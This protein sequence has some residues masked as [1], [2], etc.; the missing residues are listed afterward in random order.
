MTL[1]GLAALKT[2]IL[3]WAG[4]LLPVGLQ[5]FVLM[6]YIA[7]SCSVLKFSSGASLVD[8]RELVIYAF[9]FIG[10]ALSLNTLRRK[11]VDW[12]EGSGQRV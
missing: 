4:R 3:K 7:W 5:Y 1:R 2:E 6:Y 11:F 12:A 10:L 8:A 9:S